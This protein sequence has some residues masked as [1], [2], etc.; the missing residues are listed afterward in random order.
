LISQYSTAF[1]AICSRITAHLQSRY[2][3][4][5]LPP[6]N[7]NSL[8]LEQFAA[9]KPRNILLYL[10]RGEVHTVRLKKGISKLS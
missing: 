2:G 5:S 9:L 1:K 3:L 6:I 8:G 7:K 10:E 4:L